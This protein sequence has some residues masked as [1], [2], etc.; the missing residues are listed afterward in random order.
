MESTIFVTF[1]IVSF[2]R[3][4]YVHKLNYFRN[5]FSSSM[6]N[7]SSQ[8]DTQTRSV[9]ALYKCKSAPNSPSVLSNITPT[10]SPTN[11]ILGSLISPNKSTHSLP[12]LPTAGNCSSLNQP[13]TPYTPSV[14]DYVI[15][16]CTSATDSQQRQLSPSM[17]Y[18][19]KIDI[20][21]EE[22]EIDHRINE[23]VSEI[24]SDKCEYIE[25]PSRRE[26]PYDSIPAADK[27]NVS[28]KEL[29]SETNFTIYFR[30][31]C[32]MQIQK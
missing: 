24:P 4:D 5:P 13:L 23:N 10:P 27:P 1:I 31:N 29:L 25:S 15:F 6:K 14:D 12:C 17:G 2:H 7:K 22:D 30:L 11:I 16:T 20:V 8:S 28:E 19:E 32:W 9:N 21:F 3:K 18:L 26:N